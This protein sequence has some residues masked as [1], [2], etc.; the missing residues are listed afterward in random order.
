MTVMAKSQNAWTRKL[1]ALRSKYRLTQKEAAERIG[2]ALRTWISW[3]NAHRTPSGLAAR[4]LKNEF[5]DD[6]KKPVE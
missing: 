6:F 3:E 4:L 2:V 5:P 1:K